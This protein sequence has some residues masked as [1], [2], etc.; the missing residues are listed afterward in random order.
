MQNEFLPDETPEYR[1]PALMAARTETALRSAEL[2]PTAQEIVA[3]LS[4]LR[5]ILKR[6]K[7]H[8]HG[9][10][11]L[12]FAV[13]I[14]A[15]VVGGALTALWKLPSY[16]AM[17]VTVS[18]LAVTLFLAK[19][20]RYSQPTGLDAGELKRIS[21]V[22]GVGTLLEIERYTHF[23]ADTAAILAALT[24]ALPQMKAEDTR[25]L[26]A[27]QGERLHKVLRINIEAKGK[28][29]I[30]ANFCI[31][32]LKALEQI[33]DAP[34]IPL[35]QKLARM[36][37]LNPDSKR[38]RD[39]ANECLPLLKIRAGLAAESKTLL[40]ASA[41]EK[42]GRDALLRAASGPNVAKPNELLRPSDDPTP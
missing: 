41:P 39:A 24:D 21:G 1:T 7:T 31:A 5:R 8:W 38:I 37:T 42:A 26:N 29:A 18:V 10:L 12:I 20:S 34:E 36:N 13:W 30:R 40:R 3:Q 4:E 32:T 2:E 23:S 33:G 35:V 28:T 22:K 19:R 6:Q 25:F 17:P 11:W 14:V 9:F 15:S 16:F 27:E